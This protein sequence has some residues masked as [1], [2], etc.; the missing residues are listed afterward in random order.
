MEEIGMNEVQGMRLIYGKVWDWY[1][2]GY[3]IDI[4]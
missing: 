3:D 1:R 2:V 4:G